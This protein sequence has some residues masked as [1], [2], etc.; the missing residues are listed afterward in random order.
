MATRAQSVPS[1]AA[2]AS[3]PPPPA[4]TCASWST[5]SSSSNPTGGVAPPP[6]RQSRQGPHPHLASLERDG[7][8]HRV[9]LAGP[10]VAQ[11]LE[12]IA[13]HA[14]HAPGAPGAAPDAPPATAAATT[15]ARQ[16]RFTRNYYDH[17]AGVVGVGGTCALLDRRWL[18]IPGDGFAASPALLGWLADRGRPLAA[19]P[20]SR[21]PLVRACLDWSERT[22][23]V[24][25][26]IGAALADLALAERWA[27]RVRDSRALRLTDRG[28]TALARE[29]HA[30]FCARAARDVLIDSSVN[31]RTVHGV[32]RSAGPRLPCYGCR[33]APARETC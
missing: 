33:G 22:P 31:R 17:L 4:A 28:R 10:G 16:L 14:A 20:R 25:G 23:H 8:S 7:R 32:M 19:E 24:A 2:P 30:T 11:L 18:R 29:L 13:A 15:A 9:R 12:S 1:P 6:R 3:R 5:S 26:R 21:R 27:V